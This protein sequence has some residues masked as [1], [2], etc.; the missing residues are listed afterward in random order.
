MKE[1]FDLD[2]LDPPSV[3]L[4]RYCIHCSDASMLPLRSHGSRIQDSV[5][6]L[7]KQTSIRS[8][9]LDAHT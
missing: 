1:V 3:S 8:V 9:S 7:S 4:L 5:N 6:V 2:R